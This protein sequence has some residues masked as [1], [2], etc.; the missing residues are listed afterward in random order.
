MWVGGAAGRNRA[1]PSFPTRP[2][3][4]PSQFI[5]PVFVWDQDFTWRLIAKR[6]EWLLDLSGKH[7]QVLGKVGPLLLTAADGRMTVANQL[8]HYQD[9]QGGWR[10]WKGF[11]RTGGAWSGATWGFTFEIPRGRK[12]YFSL[13]YAGA[14]VR[15]RVS[16]D[17][18]VLS[19]ERGKLNF[20]FR[21]KTKGL[22]V[23]ALDQSWRLDVERDRLKLQAAVGSSFNCSLQANFGQNGY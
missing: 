14:G 13:Q 18:A 5:L 1:P 2:P 19:L 9:S 20:G 3:R 6:E 23:R 8:N 11:S 21:W 10:W 16:A 7:S 22:W 15:A 12:P 4:P 17:D